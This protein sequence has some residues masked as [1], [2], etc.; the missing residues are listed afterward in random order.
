MYKA[1]YKIIRHKKDKEMW[2]L[3]EGFNLYA[4]VHEDCFFDLFNYYRDLG[5]PIPDVVDIEIKIKGD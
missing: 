1:N 2:E 5:M 4:V 3:W